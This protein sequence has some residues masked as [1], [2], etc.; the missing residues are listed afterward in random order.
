M[1]ARPS[2]IR[3]TIESIRNQANQE[4]VHVDRV[5]ADAWCAVGVPDERGM[6]RDEQVVSGRVLEH[7]P[8]RS[9]AEGRARHPLITA[10]CD[11]DHLRL[12]RGVLDVATRVQ[13]VH[14]RHRQ[15]GDDHVGGERACRL[16]QLPPVADAAD[17]IARGLEQAPPCRE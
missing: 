13:P 1:N 14:F 9:G 10:G 2:S 4:L 6:D 8:G 12:W 15:I 11:E 17:D 16:E 7:E 3:A 5:E